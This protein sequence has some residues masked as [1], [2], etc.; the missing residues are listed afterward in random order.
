MSKIKSFVV[1]HKFFFIIYAFL[2]LYHFLVVN[3]AQ[4]F[5]VDEMNYSFYC[6]DYSLGF[7]SEML[8]GALYHLIVGI[9]TKEA[10]GA[11]LTVV[12]AVFFLMVAYLMDKFLIKFWDH[13]K[14]SLTLVAFFL[15]A[16]FAFNVFI[17]QFGM[18]DFNWVFFFVLALVCLQNRYLKFAVPLLAALMAMV[19]YGAAISH[20]P[21]LLIIILI[22]ILKADSKKEKTALIIILVLTVLAGAGMCLYFLLNDSKNLVYSYEDFKAFLKQRNAISVYFDYSFYKKSP[23]ELQVYYDK[24]SQT[25][26]E[27]QKSSVFATI[28]QQIG[29]ALTTIS[30]KDMLIVNAVGFVFEG[31]LLAILV[32]YF[33]QKKEIIKRLIVIAMFGFSIVIPLIGVFFSTDYSRW[34]SHAFMLLFTVVLYLLYFDFAGGMRKIAAFFS[35]VGYTFVYLVL[36]LCFGTAISPYTFFPED[37]LS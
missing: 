22:Y 10:V 3:H 18:F 4:W 2:F 17:V 6:V 15:V 35:R 5:A 12:Y 1:K 37:V 9:Y 31:F 14:A 8:P 16:P 11:Y 32:S 25:I 19:H 36:L 30:I 13:R 21:I 29:S 33:K 24:M 28:K 27:G 34:M 7:H 20:F 26:E 23:S